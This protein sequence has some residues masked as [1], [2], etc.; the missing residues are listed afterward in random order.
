M[1]FERQYHY[2]NPINDGAYQVRNDNRVERIL[3]PW[4]SYPEFWNKIFLASCVIGVT[5]DPLFLYIP[6][7]NEEKK[8]LAMDENIKFMA[9]LLRSVTDFAYVFHII[10]RL[11]NA[12]AM[13]RELGL[14]IYTGLP[15]SYLLIDILAILPIPQVSK[16]NANYI[17]H[18]KHI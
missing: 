6:I 16:S 11:R 14:S 2:F 4:G 7:I 12:S 13:A 5:I 9:L 3:N 10:F 1:D 15:W 18:M 17:Y 8:C